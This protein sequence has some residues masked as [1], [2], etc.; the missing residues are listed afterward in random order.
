MNREAAAAFQKELTAL[1]TKLAAKHNLSISKNSV[2]YGTTDLTSTIKFTEI[3]DTEDNSDLKLLKIN[4]KLEVD[5]ISHTIWQNNK[6]MMPDISYAQRIIGSTKGFLAYDEGIQDLGYGKAFQVVTRKRTKITL[7]EVT[8][9]RAYSANA[10]WIAENAHEA[11]DKSVD[12]S[13]GDR[14][15]CFA[16]EDDAEYVYTGVVKKFTRHGTAMIEMDNKQ[17]G[18]AEYDVRNIAFIL[19]R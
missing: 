11:W 15:I 7:N 13:L 6:D 2:R 3:L 4:D 14:V 1:V 10:R 19:K 9:G 8:T 5:D 17:Y 18:T 16:P 12:I